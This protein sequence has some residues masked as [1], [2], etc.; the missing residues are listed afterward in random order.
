MKAH[1]TILMQ[2]IAPWLL[3]VAGFLLETSFCTG[4]TSKP[5]P[6]LVAEPYPGSVAETYPGGGNP[7]SQVPVETRLRRFF[8]KDPGDKVE[9]YYARKYGPFTDHWVSIVPEK[10]IYEFLEKQGI[11][12]GEA[13]GDEVGGVGAGVTVIGKATSSNNAV[14]RA[15]ERLQQ[16]YVQRFVNE[17]NYDAAKHMEDKELK[18]ALQKYEPLQWAHYM[19]TKM[20]NKESTRHLMMDDV[21]FDKYFEAPERAM[22]KEQEELVRKMTDASTSGKYDEATKIGD[23]MMQLSQRQTDISWQWPVAIKCLDEMKANAY[24]TI[25]VIDVHPSQWDLSK[26]ARK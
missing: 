22:A 8:S 17:E 20:M 15:L 19:P 24:A 13:G 12:T 26:V 5:G 23:R 16:A 25:V 10:E 2:P 11:H 1:Q 4:Q 6:R 7:F 3:V 9:A 18:Q 14:T 21:L